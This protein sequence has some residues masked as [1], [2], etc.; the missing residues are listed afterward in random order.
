MHRLV[1]LLAACASPVATLRNEAPVAGPDPI[2]DMTGFAYFWSCDLRRSGKT[3]CRS[4]FELAPPA[5]A[6]ELAGSCVRTSRR[7]VECTNSVDPF[8][9]I[10]GIRAS[11]I[12]SAYGESCAI[13]DDGGVACWP[14]AGGASTY[15]VPGIRGAIDIAIDGRGCAVLFD[16]HVSCWLHRDRPVP[17]AGMSSATAIAL[18]AGTACVRQH[19]GR[20]ACWGENAYGQ[21][22]DG[23]TERR[24]QPRVV[25][26]LDHVRQIVMYAQSVCALRDDGSVWCWGGRAFSQHGERPRPLRCS[27][28]TQ[29]AVLGFATR[30]WMTLDTLCALDSQGGRI[31]L[32]DSSREAALYG[33]VSSKHW[34]DGCR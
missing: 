31:C 3:T 17:V 14:T 8:R 16:G 11:R 20:V 30:I 25:P 15:D 6:V 13:G 10:A 29:V 26:G 28:P 12:A 34:L 33:A 5:D 4:I 23:S 32:S 1:L 27:R 22:G 7:T 19:D 21:L 18:A 9:E 24:D 2:V